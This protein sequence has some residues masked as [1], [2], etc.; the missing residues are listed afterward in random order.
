MPFHNH[1]VGIV[2]FIIFLLFTVRLAR[3]YGQTQQG[4]ISKWFETSSILWISIK[5]IYNLIHVTG[6]SWPET[7]L[8][9][10]LR[11]VSRELPAELINNSE[12][13]PGFSKLQGRWV[14][15]QTTITLLSL[16]WIWMGLCTVLKLK[17]GGKILDLANL[18]VANA[19]MKKKIRKFSFTSSQSTLKNRS[20]NRLCSEGLTNFCVVR[21]NFPHR[22]PPIGKG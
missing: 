19:P 6:Y 12:S 18:L 13:R 22:P 1:N 21:H 10:P 3:K 9:K 2:T 15:Y 11:V 7:I 16:P 5:K 17:H 20:E 4:H 14:I 8:S